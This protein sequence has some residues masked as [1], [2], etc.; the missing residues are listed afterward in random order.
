MFKVIKGLVLAFTEPTMVLRA[1]EAVA[2][3][4]MAAAMAV[5]TLVASIAAVVE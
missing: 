3:M 2:L 1:I 4:I 5:V